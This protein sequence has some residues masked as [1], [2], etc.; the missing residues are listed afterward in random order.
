M[1]T[2]PTST[3]ALSTS[4]VSPSSAFPILSTS[5]NAI[6]TPFGTII[7]SIPA[8][9]S[10]SIS[11]SSEV[12]TRS[13]FF[14]T[15]SSMSSAE[16]TGPSSVTT[17]PT[18]SSTE[19]TRTSSTITS[20][21]TSPTQTTTVL[22]LSS[23]TP[24][25]ESISVTIVSA[26]PTTPCIEV[27]PNAEVTSMP[28][29][30][31]S[32]F[33]ATT[34][35]V[36]SPNSTSVTALFPDKLGPS[37][38]MLDANPS[39]KTAA[40][41]SISI[42]K[43]PINMVVLSTRRPKSGTWINSN[44]INTRPVPGSTTIPHKVKRRRRSSSSMVTTR[45]LTPQSLPITR[46]PRIPVDTKSLSTHTSHRTTLTTTQMT[47]QSRFISSPGTCDNGGT[48]TQGHCSCPRTF[49][50][51]RCELA[52]RE[53][54][55]DTVDTE[56][57]MEVSV[58]QEFSPDLNDNS[59]KVYRDFT[60]TFQDQIK[61]IYQNVQ[62]FK[63][64]QILSLRNGS[65]VVEYLVLL[66]LPFSTQLEEEYEKVKVALKEELQNVSQDGNSCQNDQV[67]CFK[68]DSIK[69]NNA[70]RTELSPEAICRRAA[71]EGYEGFYFPFLEENKLR[72]VTNCTAGLEGA[73]DCHQGQCVLQRSGPSCRCFSTDTHWFSGP[74]C[75]VAISWKALVGGLAVAGALLLLLLVV[76]LSLF[77][78]RS[79]RR[80]RQGRGRSRDDRKWFET[81]DENTAGTFSNSGFEDDSEFYEE[82]FPVALDTVDTNATVHIHRP[83]MALSSL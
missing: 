39:N 51:S 62:G 13:S 21:V 49:Y 59:S 61:K 67:L 22:T 71:A 52:A 33:T 1:V 14:P 82:N 28:T 46:V 72:C 77:V 27:G 15:S 3:A 6:S 34:E 9:M 43:I 45:K 44:F 17:F 57:G 70:T 50:G 16:S 29:V 73:I 12:S 19:T 20:P 7:S 24:C 64:V 66:E 35:T 79:R 47:T 80:D 68:P 30:P 2:P 65:I 69:V 37:P 55:L 40:P 48:W 83:E 31:L 36:T 38:P 56:V 54:Y 23:T 76:A 58:N 41:S 42:G 75:E 11:P 18:V 5:T 10:S 4:G 63:E 25:P 26:S 74:R 81:W 78:L 32:V 8:I 53:I 60:N